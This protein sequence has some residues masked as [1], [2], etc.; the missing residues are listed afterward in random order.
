MKRITDK[1]KVDLIE[2]I[3][4]EIAST[5]S[6]FDE[7]WEAATSDEFRDDAKAILL[8]VVEWLCDMRTVVYC[9]EPPNVSHICIPLPVWKELIQLSGWVNPYSPE[10]DIE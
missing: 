2:L 3:A 1:S 7:R 10:S 8:N 6:I 4:S 9:Q 5:H